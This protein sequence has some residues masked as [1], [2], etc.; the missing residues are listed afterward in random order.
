MPN[1]LNHPLTSQSDDY[2]GVAYTMQVNTDGGLIIN[3]GTSGVS[4]PYTG[5]TFRIIGAYN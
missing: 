2:S 5:Y 3:T 4:L 1:S